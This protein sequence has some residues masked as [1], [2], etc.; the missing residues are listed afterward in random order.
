MV[1]GDFNLLDSQVKMDSLVAILAMLQVTEGGV[2][3]KFTYFISCNFLYKS[4][5]Q[6]KI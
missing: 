5:L 2:L 4:I 6:T 1:P 3:L